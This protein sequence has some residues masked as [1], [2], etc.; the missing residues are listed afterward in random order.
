MLRGYAKQ[1]GQAAGVERGGEGGGLMING[2]PLIQ[3]H[4]AEA[5]HDHAPPDK[6][7]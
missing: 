2:M 4:S 7:K 6:Q 3:P 5:G 1:H